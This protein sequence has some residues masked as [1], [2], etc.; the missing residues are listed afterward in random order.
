[1]F[2]RTHVKYKELAHHVGWI[3]RKQAPTQHLK[4]TLLFYRNNVSI[5]ANQS[6]APAP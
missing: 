2:N 3:E 1:M 6:D 5:E 4:R